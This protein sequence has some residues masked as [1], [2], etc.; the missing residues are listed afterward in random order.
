MKV[1]LK[2]FIEVPEVDLDRVIA[3]IG[4]H[5]RLTRAEPG[6]LK[7][8]I[9]QRE[10]DDSRFDVDEEFVDRQADLSHQ[11]RLKTSAWA[12]ASREVKR[13]YT[14]TGLDEDYPEE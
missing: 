14:V 11:K 5:I 9:S 1:K 13:H 7:F 3:Q 12:S 2:G 6:C 8:E 4:T 10:N